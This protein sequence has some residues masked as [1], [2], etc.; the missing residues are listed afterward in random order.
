MHRGGRIVEH[1]SG[2]S[3]GFFGTLAVEE[4]SFPP[5][6][7]MRS[8]ETYEHW[9]PSCY[10]KEGHSENEVQKKAEKIEHISNG[11]VNLWIKALPK[12]IGPRKSPLVFKLF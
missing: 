7:R 12:V 1:P 4:I 6:K 5:E 3:P 11:T 8:K 9:Q 10:T 2:R